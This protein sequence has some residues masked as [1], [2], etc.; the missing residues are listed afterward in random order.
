MKRLGDVLIAVVG[1]VLFLPFLPFVWLSIRLGGGGSAY[2]K[3]ERIG[4]DGKTIRL[5]RFRVSNGEVT[6]ESGNTTNPPKQRLTLIGKILRAFKLDGWPLLYNVLKGDMSLAG[7]KPE[8]SEIVRLYSEAERRVLSVRPGIFFPYN[9]KIR[10]ENQADQNEFNRDEN[11]QKYVLPEKLKTEIEYVRDNGFGKDI[12]LVLRLIG[13]HLR[14]TL[15]DLLIQKA[16]SHNYFLFLD[17]LL[18]AASY[19]LAYEL[20]FELNVPGQEYMTFLY[21]VGIVL[22]LRIITFYAFGIYKNLWQYIGLRDLLML[23]SAATVS[24]VLIT[25]VL[26]FTG[27]ADH[28]RSIL[29][30]DWLLCISLIGGSRMAIRLFSEK[31]NVERK[32]RQNVL[33]I[34]TGEVAEMVLR[35]L[36]INGRG[37]YKII[38]F[39]DNDASMVGMMIHGVKVIGEYDDIPELASVFRVDEVL[40]AVPELSAEDMRSILKSCK[41]AGVRHRIVPAVK[42]LLNGSVHLSKFRNVELSDLFGR[43]PVKLDIS[44][45]KGFLKGRRVLVTGAG[46]SIGSELCRQ[47]ADYAPASLILVDKN[48][49]YLH[50]IR[51]ELDSQYESV[52]NYPHLCNITNYKKLRCIFEKYQPEIVFHAAA[53]KHVPLSEENPEEAVWNNVFGTKFLA[54]IAHEKGVKDFVMVSTDKAVN[55]TSIMG[56]TK[57]IAEKYIQGLAKESRTKFVTVRF[58]NV[59]NSNGSVMPIFM[60]QIEKGGPLTITHPQ[61]ERFF[62]SISEAVQLILQAV[63]MGKSGEIFILEMGKSIK[64]MDIAIELISQAGFKPF[65][66]IPIKITG[67]RPGEKLFEELVGKYEESIPTLHQNIKILK[68]NH[69][70]S[71]AQVE[72]KLGYLLN[73]EYSSEFEQLTQVLCS[74]VPEYIPNHYPS[75]SQ[76]NKLKFDAEYHKSMAVQIE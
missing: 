47:I 32:A 12:R 51:C 44:A 5:Y 37:D 11:Y 48:E 35:M 7:P 61:V 30:I 36:E 18:I 49:N 63:T 73:F 15:Y 25:A 23:I 20:R 45:I 39:I 71:L 22:S 8:K 40:I 10:P 52:A 4:K 60:K 69:I 31:V 46:G 6:N 66:D 1:V 33:I 17:L 3:D 70:E 2:I 57:R 34:G 27:K 62:M 9:D 19:F 54:S 55:P 75:E 74:L 14:K 21:C 50:E 41:E 76:N 65:E 38:G 16:K 43:Q 26:F 29:L 72:K 53:H 64:I 59:L 68:S 13:S 56:V 28:S 42:D 67:L 24:S 58:G